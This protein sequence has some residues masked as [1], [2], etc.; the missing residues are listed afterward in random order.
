ME[1]TYDSGAKVILQGPC[2]YEVESARGGFLSLGKLTARV[3]KGGGRGK[4]E[5]RNQKSEIRSNPHSPLSLIPFRRP[6]SHR[7]GHRPGHGVRRGGGRARRGGHPRPPGRRRRDRAARGQSKGQ[8]VRLGANE[9][10]RLVNR[11]DGQGPTLVRGDADAAAFAIRPGQLA[12]YAG[13]GAAE[14]LPPLAGAQPRVA[15]DPSLLA[16]YDFQQKAGCR[17]VLPNVAAG[18]IPRRTA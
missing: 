3:E 7:R 18:A 16:Y 8:T 14:A 10:V 11:A 5:I 1:I 15:R 17:D 4:A 12:A 9:S 6:H 2:T 13:G